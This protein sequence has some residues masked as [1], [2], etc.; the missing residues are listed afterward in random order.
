MR[1][2]Y[3]LADKIFIYGGNS[4]I[5]DSFQKKYHCDCRIQNLL[6]WDHL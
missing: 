6:I 3:L 4:D 2:E 5:L 1:F